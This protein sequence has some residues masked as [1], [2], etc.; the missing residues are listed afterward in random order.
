[1]TTTPQATRYQVQVHD[2][3]SWHGDG[4]PVLTAD[5]GHAHR[6]LTGAARCHARLTRANADGTYAA[7]WWRAQVYHVDRTGL[8]G[9]ERADLDYARRD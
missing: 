7:R 3:N 6:T 8:S 4:S 1:M 9:D 5:C 2:A